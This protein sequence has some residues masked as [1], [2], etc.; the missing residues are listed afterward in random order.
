MS[1]LARRFPSH[2]NRT[3]QKDGRASTSDGPIEGKR[4]NAVYVRNSGMAFVTTQLITNC[5]Y[6]INVWDMVYSHD[7]F[8]PKHLT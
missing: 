4:V 1:H 6:N 2:P 3:R 8:L 5:V 7:H